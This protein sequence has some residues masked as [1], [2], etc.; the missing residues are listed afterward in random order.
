VRALWAIAV[1]GLVLAVTACSGG[2]PEQA[3]G[4]RRAQRGCPSAWTSGWQALA[5][6]IDAPVYCPRWMPNPI[7]ARIGG[8]WNNI[9]SVDRDRSYLIGFVWQE[10]GI[11]SGEVHVNFRGYPGRTSIPRCPVSDTGQTRLVPCF[12]D[13]RGTRTAPGIRATM[14]T[15]NQGADQWHIL[16]AWRRNGSLYTISE[17]VAPPLTYRKVVRNLDRLLRSLVLVRPT[18]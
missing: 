4:G 13:P 7:D 3:S 6:R 5:N 10:T 8:Q 15:V 11:G 16:Y 9:N 12:S 17:H 2:S 18:V 1:G 14:Y